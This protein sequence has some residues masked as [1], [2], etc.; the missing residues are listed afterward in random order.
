MIHAEGTMTTPTRGSALSQTDFRLGRL[1]VA[2]IG[3]ARSVLNVR[4]GAAVAIFPK[5]S[6]QAGD[7]QTAFLCTA[8]PACLPG[9]SV[10]TA[11][12]VGDAVRWSSRVRV[13]PTVL[14]KHRLSPHSR[15][16]GNDSDN[17]SIRIFERQPLAFATSC[18]VQ[19]QQSV[20]THP[21][22]LR[23]EL[24]AKIRASLVG[25]IV[26][27][28]CLID[29]GHL[30]HGATTASENSLTVEVVFLIDET[31]AYHVAPSTM[32][33]VEF[34]AAPQRTEPVQ[35]LTD[36]GATRGSF[37]EEL[38]SD[39]A[40]KISQ[41]VRRILLSSPQ[42]TAAL[43]AIGFERPRGILVHG[44]SG[45][46]K[47]SLIKHIVQQCAHERQD[48]ERKPWL[49]F[50]HVTCGSDPASSMRAVLEAF[51]NA[52][53]FVNDEAAT[54]GSRSSS[55]ERAAVM[56]IDDIELMC[57]D[58]SRADSRDVW[59]VAQML[60]LLDGMSSTSQEQRSLNGAVFVVATS[61]NPDSMD[62]ALRRPG[63]LEREFS[64]EPPSLLERRR[65]LSVLATKFGPT[66]MKG[67]QSEAEEISRL[68]DK[69]CVGYVIADFLSL[70]REVLMIRQRRSWL[71]TEPHHTPTDTTAAI[72]L[73]ADL[74]T[75]AQNMSAS[76]L[77][78]SGKDTDAALR[79]KDTVS[80]ES[81]GGLEHVKLQLQQS[82]LW[83]IQ[84]AEAFKRLDVTAQK[85]VLLF[86]PPGCAKTTLVKA[87]A[88]S[89]GAAF[90]PLSSADVYSA[91]VGESEATIRRV[92]HRARSIAPTIIF[93]DE[94]EALVGA[95]DMSG[96]SGGSGAGS[97]VQNRIL[98]TLL[99]EMDGVSP[100]NGVVVVGA[101]NR[102]DLVDKALL[103]FVDPHCLQ[104][105][106]SIPCQEPD[107]CH[108]VTLTR[109]GRFDRLVEV[110]LPD[111]DTRARIFEVHLRDMPTRFE[112]KGAVCPQHLATIAS[113]MDD[114]T[115][116]RTAVS[117]T[118][119]QLLASATPGLSG[120][121]IESICRE[122]AV[123]ALRRNISS[124][125]VD[126]TDVWGAAKTALASATKQATLTS[127]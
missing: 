115:L 94:I 114:D 72:S 19:V 98:A 48:Q 117:T 59:Q 20:P 68:C 108:I 12:P 86:G 100:S 74:E 66:E 76:M 119:L 124:Q 6:A 64:L 78:T 46:G 15:R 112:K 80:W 69:F 92:F 60:T 30:K 45:V 81:I 104:Q 95:R 14:S 93:M 63:R 96:G 27:K 65:I 21:P 103:R 7:D 58:R 73:A 23:E 53:R 8:F 113:A 22:S 116:P 18:T 109:P 122:A 4:P 61:R 50:H 31:K 37:Q 62:P 56:L 90:V 71:A 121:E 106:V 85:G 42:E 41:Y 83:P 75:A 110:G 32:V 39:D 107:F 16:E 5:G 24:V 51:T 126:F 123:S 67:K 35:T 9:T 89:S 70:V 13:T 34:A 111:E 40:N 118:Y 17:V 36:P 97:E 57:P 49:S 29:C 11:Q 1:R 87:L 47:T 43:N 127:H 82:V 102:P 125:A 44:P 99:T 54:I 25:L 2:N 88:A 120:A 38:L 91:Y 52:S 28:G 84:H 3:T 77:R 79:S 26:V 101:T 10:L 105:Y 33:T 55:V